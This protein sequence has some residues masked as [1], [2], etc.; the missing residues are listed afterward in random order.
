MYLLK[1]LDKTRVIDAR[2]AVEICGFTRYNKASDRLRILSNA[3]YLTIIEENITH[4]HYYLLTQKGMNV[5][6]HPIKKISKDGK[7]YTYRINPPN[8]TPS[9]IRHEILCAK[10]IGKVLRENK[11]LY[12]DDILSDRDR[13]KGW[14]SHKKFISHQCDI[15]ISKY[16]VRI[17][18]ELSRK[19]QA[20]L[21]RN[22]IMNDSTFAQVW[23]I[24]NE[25]AWRY[26]NKFAYE[27]REMVFQL[28]RLKDI[29][30]ATIDCSQL[31]QELL[32][33]NSDLKEMKENAERLKRKM[34]EQ[35]TLDFD[36]ND[37]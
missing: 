5:L 18:L 21:H 16:R 7:R 33:R 23:I 30:E 22:I 11:E 34:Q 17:E 29:E 15:E 2:T 10:L 19:W 8:V 12:P 24:E 1:M 27:N 6:Y 28:I 20:K 37:K 9:N 31:Y 36:A 35:L 32:N 4:K 25:S 26:L 14:K 3:G 13:Q